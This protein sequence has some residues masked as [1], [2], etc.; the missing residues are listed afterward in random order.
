MIKPR[1][2]TNE[3]K[4]LLEVVSRDDGYSE[5]ECVLDYRIT[6]L[7]SYTSPFEKKTGI[8]LTHEWAKS[9][10]GKR[11][12]RYL[13][14]TAQTAKKV[15]DYLNHKSAKRGEIAISSR[16]EQQILSRY[17]TA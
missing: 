13:C 4:I 8:Q 6:S 10:M 15:I 5:L 17:T 7:R 14:D 11:Y 3:E 9:E 1:K 12:M 16:M 2:P